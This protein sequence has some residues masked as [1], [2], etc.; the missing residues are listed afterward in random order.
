METEIKNAKQ[1][2]MLMSNNGNKIKFNWIIVEPFCPLANYVRHITSIKIPQQTQYG[3]VIF[4]G[5]ASAPTTMN[6]DD[7][8]G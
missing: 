3:M 6:D 7:D 4:G 2:K 1:F 8:N 5:T